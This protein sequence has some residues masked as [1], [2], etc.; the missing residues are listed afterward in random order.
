MHHVIIYNTHTGSGPPCSQNGLDTPANATKECT[1][2]GENELTCTLKCR[3][4]YSYPDH[5]TSITVLCLD[6]TWSLEA[7]V[8]SISDCERELECPL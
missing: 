6:G 7:N 1:A 8:A 4:G 5:S 3:E 2:L